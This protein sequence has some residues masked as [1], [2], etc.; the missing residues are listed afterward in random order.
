[1]N[2][3]PLDW[4]ALSELVVNLSR[5]GYFD[6]C[7]ATRLDDYAYALRDSYVRNCVQFTPEQ[8][9]QIPSRLATIVASL[10]PSIHR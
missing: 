1:M 10:C 7:P 4:E 9:R 3:L 5:E 6:S 2:D 8:W